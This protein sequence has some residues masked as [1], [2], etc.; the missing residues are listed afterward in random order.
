MKLHVANTVDSRGVGPRLVPV[1][2]SSGRLLGRDL[3]EIRPQ[4]DARGDVE[5]LQIDRRLLSPCPYGAAERPRNDQLVVQ[6]R[7]LGL[8]DSRRNLA[9][10]H[11]FGLVQ[12]PALL[13]TS[14]RSLFTE[15]EG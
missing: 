14:G 9:L 3:G 2:R 15:E 7:V 12:T 11:V 5:V 10:S 13:Q 1:L 4:E 8:L 6:L